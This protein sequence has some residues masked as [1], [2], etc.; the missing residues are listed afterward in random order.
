[1][2]FIM[3]FKGLLIGIIIALPF[4]PIGVMCMQHSV[5]RGMTYGLVAG[6]GAALADAMFGALAG[7]G[8]SMSSEFLEA[9]QI[10]LQIIGAVFLCFLGVK[11]YFSLPKSVAEVEDSES[12]QKIFAGTFI[13]TLTNPFTLLCFAGIYTGLGICLSGEGVLATLVLSA[14]VFVGSAF[15]WILISFGMSLLKHKVDLKWVGNINRIS[16]I[17]LI[18]FGLA[19]SLAIVQQVFY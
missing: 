3:F 4:G 11:S 15:W 12:F 17:V 18:C 14:G 5:I 9:N 8:V 16:G 19:A 6:L 1:M 13:L 2:L 10:L 7:F